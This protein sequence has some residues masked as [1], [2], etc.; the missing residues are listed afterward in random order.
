MEVCSQQLSAIKD[1]LS[2]ADWK[3]VVIA[4][5]PVWAIGINNSI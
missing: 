5:E 4:Y 1:A 3:R 2:V